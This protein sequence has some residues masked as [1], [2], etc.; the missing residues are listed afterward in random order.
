VDL[1]LLKS[2]N[3]LN[4]Q[5]P[6]TLLAAVSPVLRQL[7]AS[8]SCHQDEAV[9]LLP[10]VGRATLQTLVT[11]LDT[12][13]TK[14][15]VKGRESVEKTLSSLGDL[16]EM[17]GIV[18]LF[19]I[20]DVHVDEEVITTKP[21]NKDQ[22]ESAPDK[23]NIFSLEWMLN[24]EVHIEVKNMEIETDEEY[25]E[26]EGTEIVHIV[27]EVDDLVYEESN[28]HHIQSSEEYIVEDEIGSDVD[29]VRVSF[30]GVSPVIQDLLKKHCDREDACLVED[31]ANDSDDDVD[32]FVEPELAISSPEDCE[33]GA[34]QYQLVPPLSECSE[35]QHP[36]NL[37]SHNPGH[38]Y[39]LNKVYPGSKG[40]TTLY[41]CCVKKGSMGCKGKCKVKLGRGNK[42]ELVQP[43]FMEHNH[44]PEERTELHNCS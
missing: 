23:V 9:I 3:G 18:G 16:M 6:I 1:V 17:L 11:L 21:D 43:S 28:N 44:A 8:N 39:N 27:K 32:P 15:N 20:T 25:C 41:Y 2:Y 34:T 40:V 10:V 14:V 26:M 19:N 29:I 30:A 38:K 22:R 36:S 12:G 13:V 5:L 42:L 35:G 33:A 4:V 24:A 37:V 31:V 7:L